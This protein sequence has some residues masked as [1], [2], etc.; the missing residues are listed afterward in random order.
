M[1]V[2]GKDKMEVMDAEAKPSD[3]R[4]FL[5]NMAAYVL[6]NDVMLNDGETIGFSAE[7]KHS[8]TRSEGAALPGMTLKIEY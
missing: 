5:L 3:A 2:F 4:D 8:I 1:S 6:E 7:D